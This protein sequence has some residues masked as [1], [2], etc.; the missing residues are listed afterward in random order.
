MV[1][2]EE[3]VQHQGGEE[4]EGEGD[5]ARETEILLE[6]QSGSSKGPSK[7]GVDELFSFLNDHQQ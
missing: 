5:L 6:P 1:L 7:V 2:L 4:G 3:G